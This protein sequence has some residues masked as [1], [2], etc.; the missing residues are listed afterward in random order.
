MFKII[1]VDGFLAIRENTDLFYVYRCMVHKTLAVNYSQALPSRYSIHMNSDVVNSI[2][3][4]VPVDY[5]NW[6]KDPK[7]G[8]PMDIGFISRTGNGKDDPGLANPGIISQLT[9]SKWQLYRYLDDNSPIDRIDKG[10]WQKVEIALED[11]TG[12]TGTPPWVAG[13]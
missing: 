7:H 6:D 10:V 11:L 1:N 2:C 5:E 12:G 8:L 3:P 4:W 13:P 9:Y